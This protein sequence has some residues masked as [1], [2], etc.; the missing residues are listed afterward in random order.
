MKPWDLGH[1]RSAEIDLMLQPARA[2]RQARLSPTGEAGLSAS[3]GA[4]DP[5]IAA[6]F[7]AKA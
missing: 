4:I 5:E 6:L 7:E 1:Y 2:L 3:Q